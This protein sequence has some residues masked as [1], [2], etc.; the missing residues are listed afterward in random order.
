MRQGSGGRPETPVGPR[1][2]PVGAKG[3]KPLEFRDFID[4]KGTRHVHNIISNLF[5][6]PPRYEEFSSNN[7]QI[8]YCPN[9]TPLF[10]TASLLV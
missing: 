9:I 3:A 4:F 8:L 7:S 5:F 2:S 1:E 10:A 6:Q